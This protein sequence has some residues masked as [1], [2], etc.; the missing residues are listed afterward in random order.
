MSTDQLPVA[1]SQE[2]RR[3]ETALRES[4]MLRELAEL[5][6]SSLDIEHILYVLVKRTTQVCDVERCCV[7]LLE[8]T[9][10]NLH[11]K[12]YHIATKQL[13]N[14]MV[15]AADRIWYRTPLSMDDPAVHRQ[16]R[17][18]DLLRTEAPLLGQGR[19]RSAG[20]TVVEGAHG[21]SGS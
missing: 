12:T 7:W 8:E 2:Q 13:D 11:P 17:P 15:E 4:E 20:I 6:A 14:R 21:A 3:L 10:G 19:D 9:G 16:R 1:N 5:L 18:G